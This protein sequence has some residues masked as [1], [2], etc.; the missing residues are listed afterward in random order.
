MKGHGLGT[1]VFARM[2]A[3]LAFD[4][5]DLAAAVVVVVGLHVDDSVAV[6]VPLMRMN[7]SRES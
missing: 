7:R 6:V 4:E 2:E 5:D 1:V 3:V